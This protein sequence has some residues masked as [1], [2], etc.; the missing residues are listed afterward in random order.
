MEDNG[1]TESV[2]LLLLAESELFSDRWAAEGTI[3]KV[4]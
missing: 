2:P 3:V 4:T 1:A